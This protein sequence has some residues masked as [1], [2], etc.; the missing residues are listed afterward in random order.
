MPF[1]GRIPSGPWGIQ[2]ASTEHSHG[3][4]TT[5]LLFTYCMRFSCVGVLLEVPSPLHASK[6]LLNVPMEFPYSRRT[7]RAWAM[8]I[9]VHPPIIKRLDLVVRGWAG[10]AHVGGSCLGEMR[11]TARPSPLLSASS[12]CGLGSVG[13][14]WPC[15]E[16]DRVRPP[17]SS[18]FSTVVAELLLL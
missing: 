16:G 17:S 1:R 10:E 15:R 11:N 18:P 12:P 3:S 14:R 9:E 8:S 5:A 13:F 7:R 4:N 6:S 2:W